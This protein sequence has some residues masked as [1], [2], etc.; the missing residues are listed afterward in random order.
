[1]ANGAEFRTD[2]TG[3]E[4][5]AYDYTYLPPRAFAKPVPALGLRFSGSMA[6]PIRR[7]ECRRC[8]TR[9]SNLGTT[10]DV[11]SA[12]GRASVT[13]YCGRWCGE[14]MTVVIG[15]RAGPTFTEAEHLLGSAQ[16]R[17]ALKNPRPIFRA[18]P[19][20]LRCAGSTEP[21]EGTSAIHF[22]QSRG[23]VEATARK[24]V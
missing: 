5:Y 15:S 1:M 8:C 22:W 3:D 16:L 9:L 13:G 20:A 24:I 19:P 14:A 2:G 21:N 17:L 11:A 7:Q 6:D 10:G 12:F 23:T 18:R 4:K